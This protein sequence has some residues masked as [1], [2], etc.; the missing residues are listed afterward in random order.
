MVVAGEQAV[1]GEF[2]GNHQGKVRVVLVRLIE[3]QIW[4]LPVHA[5]YVRGGHN[6]ETIMPAVTSFHEKTAP[7]VF[8]LKPNNLVSPCISIA[9]SELLSTLLDLRVNVYG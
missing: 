7:P 9:L 3:T 6:K 8:I 5:N 1:W 2:S 4:H